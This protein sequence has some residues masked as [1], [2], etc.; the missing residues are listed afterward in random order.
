ML[1]P[2]WV[3][4]VVLLGREIRRR[5]ASKRVTRTTSRRV[6]AAEA[7]V[8]NGQEQKSNKFLGFGLLFGSLMISKKSAPHSSGYSA[9]QQEL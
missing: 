2:D 1:W 7:I 8:T 6:G 4:F 5:K 3:G 9:R